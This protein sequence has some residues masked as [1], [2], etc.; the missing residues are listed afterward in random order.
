[1]YY[2]LPSRCGLSSFIILT[3]KWINCTSLS[4]DCPSKNEN[5]FIIQSSSCHP[6]C[7]VNYFQKPCK[8]NIINTIVNQCLACE[9]ER[10]TLIFKISETLN[11]LFCLTMFSYSQHA[12]AWSKMHRLLTS[13][14]CMV[15]EASALRN[16]FTCIIISVGVPKKN[17]TQLM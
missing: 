12:Y 4:K 5:S 13:L 14:L 9:C 2:I 1:M 10:K 7:T 11:H 8:M 6:R 15:F 16:Q 17:E 3:Y